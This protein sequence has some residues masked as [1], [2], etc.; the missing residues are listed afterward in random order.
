MVLQQ[1]QQQEYRRGQR[2][3]GWRRRRRS[4]GRQR[5]GGIRDS[6]RMGP[7]TRVS[8]IRVHVRTSPSGPTWLTFSCKH[9]TARIGPSSS[10]PKGKE[11]SMQGPNGIATHSSGP[12]PYI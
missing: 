11:H 2:G 4:W 5:G 6:E 10:L 7:G 12:T 8:V 9:P 3:G 1:Q